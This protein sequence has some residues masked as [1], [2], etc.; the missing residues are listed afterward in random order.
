MSQKMLTQYDEKLKN[1]DVL[2][3]SRYESGVDIGEVISGDSLL[4]HYLVSVSPCQWAGRDK[5]VGYLYRWLE[6][7]MNSVLN[8]KV[9]V[10]TFN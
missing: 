7:Q 10:R 6:L 4:C 3:L 8:V 9:L 1:V 2:L 5:E